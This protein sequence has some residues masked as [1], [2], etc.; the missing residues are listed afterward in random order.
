MGETGL[1]PT[2]VEPTEGEVM[3]EVAGA[4]P[5]WTEGT[6]VD[7]LFELEEAPPQAL[8]PVREQ[9]ESAVLG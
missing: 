2:Q 3:E 9:P 6:E 1:L 7:R 8:Q 5:L 4:V